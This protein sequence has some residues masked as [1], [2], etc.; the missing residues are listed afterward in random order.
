MKIRQ[1]RDEDFAAIMEITLSAF[2][3]IH[4]SFREI[5]G[6]R[7]FN[8]VYPDWK[9]SNRE[10]L[11]SLCEGVDK[12]NILV[13]EEDHAVIGFISYFLNPQEKSG[14]L[15]LNAVHPAHQNK[16]IGTRMYKHVLKRMKT[17]GIKV[18]QVGT[19]GDPSHL[20]ARRVYEKS[21]FV[22]LQLVRYYKAL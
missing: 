13:A 4:E 15:G 22:T 18:V 6:S 3:P 20:Q 8:C 16:G 10:Y 17:R 19:G 14:E 11:K 12:K 9:K 21:G 7:I 1:F 5:L 2:T